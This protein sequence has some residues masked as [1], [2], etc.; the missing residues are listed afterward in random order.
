[1][2]H[3]RQIIIWSLGSATIS[4]CRHFTNFI[5]N[6]SH[7]L[8]IPYVV[9]HYLCILLSFPTVCIITYVGLCMQ[10]PSIHEQQ[11]PFFGPV[12]NSGLSAALIHTIRVNGQFTINS[13]LCFFHSLWYIING[14]P[15]VVN[16]LPYTD[17]LFTV[18]HTACPK[19]VDKIF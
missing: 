13:A 3:C 5:Y 12:L 14:C 17:L 2:C 16:S 4:C 9:W 18:H 19:I 8:L 11:P 1:M 6:C 10:T 15:F 7:A